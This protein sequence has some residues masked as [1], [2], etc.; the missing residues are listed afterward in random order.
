MTLR[1]LYYGDNLQVLRDHIKDESVD[2]IYLDPPFNSN[3]SYNILFKE[4]TGE[5]SESQIEAFTD[6]WQWNESAELAF[7]EVRRSGNVPAFECWAIAQV[8]AYPKT[9]RAKKGAD[10]GIDGIICFTGQDKKTERAMV[11]VKAA[12]TGVY[13]G[14][15]G[16]SYPRLQIITLPEIF[17]GKKPKIPL[18]NPNAGFKR[19]KREEPKN[20]ELD[21]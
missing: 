17:Q 14:V 7:D 11:Q 1:Q 15:D 2:L 5:G 9:G 8:D 4:P 10:A 21:V 20:G 16:K 18:V 12:A 3:A 6:T 19:A 13:H